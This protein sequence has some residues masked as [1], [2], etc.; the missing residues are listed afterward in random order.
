MQMPQIMPVRK[1]C[2]RT[3]SF[4]GRA[5]SE[6]WGAVFVCGSFR[7][8]NM[9]IPAR[10]SGMSAM[11]APAKVTGANKSF[12]QMTIWGPRTAETMPAPRIQ[13][14]ALGL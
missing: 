4:S 3:I 14:I 7:K 1:R 5:G 6:L 9:P 13:E 12:A 10:Q 2:V 11:K 8:E